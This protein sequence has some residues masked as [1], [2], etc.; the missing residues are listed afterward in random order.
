MILDRAQSSALRRAAADSVV[1][2]GPSGTGKSSLANAIAVQAAQA[3]LTCLLVGTSPE[4]DKPLVYRAARACHPILARRAQVSNRAIINRQKISPLDAR[5]RLNPSAMQ[6]AV[7]VLQRA[8]RKGRPWETS[9]GIGTL[10]GIGDVD[11]LGETPGDSDRSRCGRSAIARRRNNSVVEGAIRSLGDY[12]CA[13]VRRISAQGRSAGVRAVSAPQGQ[14]DAE[15]ARRDGQG[16]GDVHDPGG[17][18]ADA[19]EAVL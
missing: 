14:D 2:R 16:S 5:G 3:G 7:R 1:V 8:P 6:T 10:G 19:S 4:L 17:V 11:S 15:L 13:E 12:R 18:P 9:V